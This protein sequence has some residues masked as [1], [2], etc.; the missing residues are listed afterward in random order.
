[1]KNY[2]S[3]ILTTLLIIGALAGCA[4]QTNTLEQS[5]VSDTVALTSTLESE[6]M[7][8]VSFSKEDYEKLLV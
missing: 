8:D 4:G 1:M 5:V 3:F 2:L 6:D 7:P